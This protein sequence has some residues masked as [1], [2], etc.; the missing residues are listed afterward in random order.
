MA[1]RRTVWKWHFH[2]AGSSPAVT[3]IL[4]SAP[5]QAQGFP[6]KNSPPPSNPQHSGVGTPSSPHSSH[7]LWGQRAEK[8][9]S[10][11]LLHE[12]TQPG[13]WGT[14]TPRAGGTVPHTPLAPG[15]AEPCTQIQQG[16]LLN[17][18]SSNFL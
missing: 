11:H 10:S 2:E 5:T 16:P 4:S 3:C 14:A 13:P 1:G 6:H 15:T 12:Q 7:P 8:A 9:V 18:Y 17:F